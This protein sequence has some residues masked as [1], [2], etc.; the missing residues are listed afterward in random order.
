MDIFQV[1]YDSRDEEKSIKMARYMKN[2]FPF[3]GIAKP[4]RMKLSKSFMKQRKKDIKIDWSLVSKCYNM[5]EREFH[6][7]ALDYVSLLKE[8][9]TLEDISNI[10]KLILTNSWWDSVDCIDAIVGNM[11]LKYPEL[12]ESTILKWI[13]SDNIWLKRVAIDFQLKYKEK[14]DTDI[15]T[16]AI[17]ANCNTD[18]FFVNKAIGWSLREYSKTNKEWVKKFLEDNKLPA[19]SVREA[20]KYI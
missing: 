16:K 7:L 1:F 4:E 8:K 11:C 10:E 17:L 6:Y 14:T 3:L 13:Y 20:S 5:P 12:K 15:L 2:K 19:L 9:L 18:E